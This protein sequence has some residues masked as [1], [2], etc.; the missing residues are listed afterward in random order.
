MRSIFDIDI[1]VAPKTDK[2]KYGVPAMIYN[3]DLKRVAAHPSGV[4]LEP[5][6]IDPLTNLA[7][8]DY[9]YGNEKGFMKVDVLNNSVYSEFNSKADVLKCLEIEPDWDYLKDENI[10]KS[11]PHIGKH[12]DL[13]KKIQPKS[14]EELADVLALIRPGKIDQIDNYIKDKAKVRK[15]LYK[16]SG[17]MYF[18]KSHAISYAVMIVVILNKRKLYDIKW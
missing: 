13:I 17:G 5:V 6:P 4:Y 15:N 7:A 11:L 12:Y 18:K 10:V 3:E 14:V 1:D 16:R 2:T 9:E 8:F